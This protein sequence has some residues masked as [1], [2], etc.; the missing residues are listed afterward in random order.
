MNNDS[1]DST[2]SQ[3]CHVGEPA[4]TQDTLNA[5]NLPLEFTVIPRDFLLK[6]ASR[7]KRRST[8]TRLFAAA[9]YRWGLLLR[10]C[11]RSGRIGSLGEAEASSA[12]KQLAEE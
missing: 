9:W 6:Y 2:D 12:G 8:V 11:E 5:Q 10:R 4:A 3:P 7:N 1:T